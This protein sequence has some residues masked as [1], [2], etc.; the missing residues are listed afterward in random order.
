MQV[1]APYNR[2]LDRPF[3]V[4][5][6]SWR[7]LVVIGKVQEKMSR[8]VGSRALGHVIR[9]TRSPQ[10]LIMWPVLD[11]GVTQGKSRPEAPW[12]A[13]RNFIDGS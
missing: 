12:A 4:L 13:H 2:G 11:L 8:S 6:M 9:G 1:S 7:F 3:L 10:G 5:G